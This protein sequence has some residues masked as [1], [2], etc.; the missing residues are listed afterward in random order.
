VFLKQICFIILVCLSGLTTL[1]EADPIGSA[2]LKP[3]SNDKK[4]PTVFELLDKYTRAL[5]SAESFIDSFESVHK[6]SYHILGYSPRLIGAK[7]YRRGL[8][9]SDGRCRYFREYQWGDINPK[10]RNLSEDAPH[11]KCS[12]VS[13]KMSYAHTKLINEPSLTGKVICWAG[14]KKEVFSR[15]N[16]NS[17]ILGFMG[18]DERLDTVL[19]RADRISVRS[20]TKALGDSHFYVIDAQ[21]KY[22]KYSVW[23]DPGHDYHPIKITMKA[24]EG[25][26]HFDKGI[27]PK[28]HKRTAYLNNVRFEKVDNIW[29]PIE[30]DRGYHYIY[31]SSKSF[32]KGNTH[33]KRISIVLNPNHEELGSFNNP[34]EDPEQDPELVNG[35]KINIIG[36]EARYTWRNGK[37]V[38]KAGHV[39]LYSKTEK[40]E[41]AKR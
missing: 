8:N 3:K 37:I 14:T 13:G 26:E 2:D 19:R 22:G 9:R 5:D 35:T 23:L 17:H 40:P 24:T 34:L 39:I 29:I 33:F 1:I 12:V 38:D 30:A 18:S 7:A 15:N 27:L 21:T 28:G 36:D 16:T 32:S 20:V 25:D 10:L 4:F 31:G 6:F 41:K 11:Y